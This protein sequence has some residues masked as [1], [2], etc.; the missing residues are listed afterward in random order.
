MDGDGIIHSW[1]LLGLLHW[2]RNS[3]TGH[4]TALH[5][6]RQIKIIDSESKWCWF[7]STSQSRYISSIDMLYIFKYK[8]F[9]FM[10]DIDFKCGVANSPA[11]RIVGGIVSEANEYPW[12]VFLNLYFWSGDRATCTGTLIGSKWILT[13]A[14]CSFG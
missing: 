9:N 4:S 6:Q 10:F 7:Y 11:S 5:C 8:I 2:G 12:T 13:A 14:H 1:F 3:I